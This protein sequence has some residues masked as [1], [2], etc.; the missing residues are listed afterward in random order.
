[1][2][3]VVMDGN[4]AYLFGYRDA[5]TGHAPSSIYFKPFNGDYLTGYCDGLGDILIT[6]T[7][8]AVGKIDDMI[9]EAGYVRPE[10]DD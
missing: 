9:T 3:V 4:G 5:C 2:R 8:D 7:T 1:M 10:G 6:Q